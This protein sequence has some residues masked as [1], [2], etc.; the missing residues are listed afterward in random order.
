V[1]SSA[2]VDDVSASVVD[3]VLAPATGSVV[4]V[5]V[6]LVLVEVVELV[7]VVVQTT[8]AWRNALTHD[9]TG[10]AERTHFGPQS[11]RSL[12]SKRR[13]QSARS[14]SASRHRSAHPRTRV[15]RPG[16]PCASGRHPLRHE[17]NARRQVLR[18]FLAV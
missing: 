6:R 9:L 13:A 5:V 16:A 3:V 8:S 10:T 4:V 2:N 17:F 11:F 14:P 15:H 12:D 18:V 7:E 1:V